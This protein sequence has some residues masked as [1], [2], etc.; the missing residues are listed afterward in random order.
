M[1]GAVAGV[2]ARCL[3]APLDVLR[4]RLQLDVMQ[5]PPWQHIWE[6]SS[7]R[8]WFR[9]NAPATQLWMAYTGVQ[10][11]VYQHLQQQQQQQT[12]GG[13]AS[14]HPFVAGAVAG[15]CA[16]LVTYPLDLC[17]TA[18]AAKQQH[19]Q[20][21]ASTTSASTLS[22]RTMM[23]FAK[24]IHQQHGW[25]GFY[26]GVGPAVG[27]VVPYT[28]L[29]FWIYETLMAM[30]SSSS[31]QKTGDP[32][33]CGAVSGAVSKT[34][35]YPLDTAKKR[36]QAQAFF[37]AGTEYHYHNTVDCILTMIRSEGIMSLYRGYIPSVLKTSLSTSLTFYLFNTTQRLISTVLDGTDGQGFVMPI[38]TDKSRQQGMRVRRQEEEEEEQYRAD[39]RELSEEDNG[40]MGG[41]GPTFSATSPVNK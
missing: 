2:G 16:T 39:G 9:G 5:K 21:T 15:L 26:A 24:A 13:V 29:S 33:F 40:M 19:L 7:V 31:Q 4:I 8:C 20:M 22:S 17:R 41:T 18:L 37:M 36:L 10:F 11:S 27:Q 30:S 25:R 34:I 1:S 3:T 23:G 14:H 12:T 35:V 6:S 28:G 38:R 32:A